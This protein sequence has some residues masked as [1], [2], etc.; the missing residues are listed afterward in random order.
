MYMQ[1]ETR[2]F[3]YC[4]CSCFLSRLFQI[5]LCSRPQVPHHRQSLAINKKWLGLREGV[6]YAAAA[7]PHSHTVQPSPLA[8]TK[9]DTQTRTYAHLDNRIPELQ[10]LSGLS[11]HVTHAHNGL[12]CE[13]CCKPAVLHRRLQGYAHTC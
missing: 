2:S 5:V 10:P 8:V 13:G 9:A 4:H 6:I 1:A 11:R 7:T 3:A 12:L